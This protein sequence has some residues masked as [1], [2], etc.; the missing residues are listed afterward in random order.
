MA[1][2]QAWGL[3]AGDRS[4][5]PADGALT[6]GG[7]EAS[8]VAGNLTTFPLGDWA[9]QKPCPLQVTINRIIYTRPNGTSDVLNAASIVACIDPFQD[10]FTFPKDVYQKFANITSHNTSYPALTYPTNGAPD[11]NL[12]II[13]DNNY[14]TV[15]PNPELVALDRGSDQF[16]HYVITNSSIVDADISNT[17]QTDPNTAQA[18]LGALY[19]TF[20][21]LVVDYE[22][23]LFQLAPAVPANQPTI[24]QA[25]KS[26]CTQIPT[27][28]SVP[29]VLPAPAPHRDS[30]RIGAIVGGTVGGVAGIAIMALLL[31]FIRRFLLRRKAQRSSV[32]QNHAPGFSAPIASPT[33]TELDSPTSPSELPL[34]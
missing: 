6:I 27:N 16:G 28:A 14:T 2:S 9:I 24:S 4:L 3:W 23:D 31:L 19:L 25:L 12:T 22:S 18:V 29:S 20:N 17:A 10:R 26:I 32:V 34:V 1:P 33:L 21:Y 7:Y 8:R 13:L 11:G 30:G 15:V 5:S